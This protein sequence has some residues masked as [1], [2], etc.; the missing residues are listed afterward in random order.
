MII[1]TIKQ[2]QANN[3]RH[4]Q[5][6]SKN[7]KHPKQQFRNGGETINPITNNKENN[8][9]MTIAIFSQKVVPLL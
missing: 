1:I 4:W 7:C 2:I 9:A 3:C 6:T 8:M 5:I